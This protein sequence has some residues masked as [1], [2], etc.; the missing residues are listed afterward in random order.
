VAIVHITGL[1]RA[2]IESP[3]CVDVFRWRNRGNPSLDNFFKIG[4]SVMPNSRFQFKLY[5]YPQGE[6]DRGLPAIERLMVEDHMTGWAFGGLNPAYM[7]FWFCSDTDPDATIPHV[8][9][10]TFLQPYDDD[11]LHDFHKAKVRL[12]FQKTTRSV[13]GTVAELIST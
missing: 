10:Y 13:V 4:K 2:K 8:L 12:L 7:D 5:L 3:V 9:R 6:I 11:Q 1:R